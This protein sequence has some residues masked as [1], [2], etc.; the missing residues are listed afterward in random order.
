MS[1]ITT[2]SMARIYD[3]FLDRDRQ[4]SCAYFEAPDRSLE[5]AQ[6]AK[7]RHLAAKL[8]I[9]P[10]MRVLDIGSGWGGLG[11]LS[12]GGLRR[13]GRRRDAVERAA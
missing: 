4:Y 5:D 2:I 12:R 13:R 10:G 11:A 1:R 6:L 9:E 8:S 3:L 7:K